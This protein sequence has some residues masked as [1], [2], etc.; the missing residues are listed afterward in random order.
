MSTI[1]SEDVEVHIN[2]WVREHGTERGFAANN[3]KRYG[4]ATA[5]GLERW[6]QRNRHKSI[7]PDIRGTGNNGG[8]RHRTI[9]KGGKGH[10]INTQD[11]QSIQRRLGKYNPERNPPTG[12]RSTL[13]NHDWLTKFDVTY[14]WKRTEER[15][16]VIEHL[17]SRQGLIIIHRGFGKSKIQWGLITRKILE[18]GWSRLEIT[19]GKR[20]AKKIY[21]KVKG[22]LHRKEIRE[23]YGDIIEGFDGSE[24]TM[25]L[26]DPIDDDPA[27]T[28][29]TRGGSIIGMHPREIGIHDFLQRKFKSDESE[30]DL[31]DW[32]DEVASYLRTYEIGKETRIVGVITRKG[33]DDLYSYMFSKG[34]K[35]FHRLAIEKLEGRWAE[36]LEDFIIDDDGMAIGMREQIGKFK[37]L[38]CPNWPIHA[39]LFER[40][41]N[42]HAFEQQMQGRIVPKEGNYFHLDDWNASMVDLPLLTY[43][44]SAME[45]FTDPAFGESG[46]GSDS[47][48]LVA[49]WYMGEMHIIDLKVGAF[50]TT[51]QEV[52]AVKL[53]ADYGCI[54]IHL[55]D[56]FAQMS[57]A[58][59]RNSPIM[60][61][62]GM[63]LFHQKLLPG[64][65]GEP[66]KAQRINFIQKP[67]RM[68]RIKLNRNCN[69]QDDYKKQYLNY[70]G[71]TKKGES[72]DVLDVV[73][74]AYNYLS[75]KHGSGTKGKINQSGWGK[76]FG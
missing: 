37:T 26:I 54:S 74:T 66:G 65:T 72:W 41:V 13:D 48:L 62:K 3:Y 4:Y 30:E 27:L 21:K 23:F 70:R 8:Q 68:R 63:R 58:Y 16:D 61:L 38:H 69:Q 1:Q 20:Q 10:N 50:G 31:R 59:D 47:A 25:E 28:V 42:Y 15:D 57:R 9:Q 33:P 43:G 32:W 6:L 75:K 12:F 49:T 46:K 55:E 36:S 11:L 40:F 60:K 17:W 45:L 29:A 76:R 5:R 24:L 19:D 64:G 53:H 51:K 73:A 52:E 22:L 18:L 71:I 35:Q 67:Y 34:L 14:T 39:L 44:S 56:N 2:A 7:R